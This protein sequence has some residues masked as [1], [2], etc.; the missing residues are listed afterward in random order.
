MTVSEIDEM[1]KE[2]IDHETGEIFDADQFEHLNNLRDEAIEE[3][4]MDI[5]RLRNDLISLK[6]GK[7]SLE[8]VIS[9]KNQQI[10]RLKNE[11]MI[12]LDGCKF[13]SELVKINYRTNKSVVI[14]DYSHIPDE[15]IKHNDPDVD[16]NALKKA[17]KEGRSFEGVYIKESVSVIIQ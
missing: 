1:I 5:K 11:L 4:A 17:M 16:K 3:K 14:D 2:C 6:A 12:D 8:E 15:F 9:Q 10:E 13:A 7:E